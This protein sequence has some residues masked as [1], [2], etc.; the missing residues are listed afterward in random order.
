[1]KKILVLALSLFFAASVSVFATGD[2]KESKDKKDTKEEV[3]KE[4][5]KGPR[6][7][8]YHPM[9]YNLQTSEVNSVEADHPAKKVMGPRAKNSTPGDYKFESGDLNTMSTNEARKNLKGPRAKNYRP[10]KQYEVTYL[11]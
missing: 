7:K 6:A 5:L 1:M 8:N 9:K 2:G 4:H 11:I 10:G 3:K